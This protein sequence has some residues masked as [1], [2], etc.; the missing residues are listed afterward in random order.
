MYG[1]PC[2]LSVTIC[3]EYLFQSFFIVCVALNLN[4]HIVASCFIFRCSHSMSFDG[5][6]NPF[7]YKV[8]TDKD[9]L[10][11]HFVNCFLSC[12]SFVPLYVSCCIAL[13]LIDFCGDMIWFFIRYFVYF[14]LGICGYCVTSM[15]HF[16]VITIYFKW[17]I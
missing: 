17:I 16:R 8:I 7:T 13:W 1:Y 5:E 11:Y 2:S 12:H 9:L 15:E 14:S 4:R 3:M 10:F 6:F